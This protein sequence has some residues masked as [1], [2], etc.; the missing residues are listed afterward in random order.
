M[1]KFA[2][3][4]AV[5]DVVLFQFE[6][7]YSPVRQGTVT[8]VGDTSLDVETEPNNT[9]IVSEHHWIHKI[10]TRENYS[11]IQK[12]LSDTKRLK[13]TKNLEQ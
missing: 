10:R 8:R 1:S 12:L 11:P 2:E 13:T 5:G 4:Y 3:S 6:K 9:W 7:N